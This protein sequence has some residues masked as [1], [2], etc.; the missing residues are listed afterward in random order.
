MTQLT[1]PI[2]CPTLG[3]AAWWA[4]DCLWSHGLFASDE[5]GL[6]GAP[7]LTSDKVWLLEVFWP[8]FPLECD[9]R[10]MFRSAPRHPCYPSLSLGSQRRAELGDQLEQQLWELGTSRRSTMHASGTLDLSHRPAVLHHPRK[11][12]SLRWKPLGSQ[13]KLWATCVFPFFGAGED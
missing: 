2:V 11:V 7:P 8:Q 5:M 12:V 9:G 10:S 6:N 3:S 13:E 1:Q 4:P